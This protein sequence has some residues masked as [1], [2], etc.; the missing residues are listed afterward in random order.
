MSKGYSDIFLEPFVAKFPEMKYVTRSEYTE[1]VKLEKIRQARDQL[2]KYANDDKLRK[3]S[4]TYT[5]VRVILVYRG[6]ERERVCCE[7]SE[8]FQAE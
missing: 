5:L 6:W 7:E 4:Q 3:L 1:E 8:G 2:R